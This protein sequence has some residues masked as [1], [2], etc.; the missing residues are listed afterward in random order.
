MAQNYPVKP[1]TIVVPFAAGG[2][3]DA[4]ARMIA[5]PMTQF[6]GQTVIV[7]NTAGAGGT[8]GANRV[9]KANPDG[10]MIF[11]HHVGMSTAPALYPKLPYD[12]VNDFEFIGQVVDVPLTLIARKN[13]PANNFKELEAYL[14]KNQEKVTMGNAGPGAVSQLCSMLF[15]NKMGIKLTEVPYKGTGPAMTDLLGGTIDIMC[16]QTTNTVANIRADKVKVFGTTTL[17]RLKS[18]PNI[19]TLDEQGFKGFEVVAW[20]GLYAPKGTPPAVMEKLNAALKNALANSEIKARLADLSVE[21]AS[22]ENVSASGLK[23]QLES[24]IKRWTPIIKAAG[25]TAD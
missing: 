11:L 25:V 2:P 15:T 1:V 23:K 21:E 4:V 6:L 13:I 17:K 10:Y 5:V 8:I 16:D 3:T 19:P 22:A 20:H 9:A 18:L 12:P 7:E 24:E 14:K